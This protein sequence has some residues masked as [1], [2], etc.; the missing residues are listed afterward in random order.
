MDYDR[1]DWVVYDIDS[2]YS[3]ISTDGSSKIGSFGGCAPG[4]EYLYRSTCPKVGI[5]MD[6]HGTMNRIVAKPIQ[7]LHDYPNLDI[8]ITNLNLYLSLLIP[9]GHSTTLTLTFSVHALSEDL[10]AKVK[11]EKVIPPLPLPLPHDTNCN[12]F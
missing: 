10:A 7:Y 5:L 1:Y 8:N 11:K 12:K 2:K 3:S 4:V 6:T 9:Q